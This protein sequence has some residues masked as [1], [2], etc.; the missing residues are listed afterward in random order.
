MWADRWMDGWIGWWMGDWVTEWVNWWVD[1]WMNVWVRWLHRMQWGW[2]HSPD[3]PRMW[4]PEVWGNILL[5]ST[6]LI[7]D[8]YSINDCQVCESMRIN[9]HQPVHRV[10]PNLIP[11]LASVFCVNQIWKH[12]PL[13]FLML[14][15]LEKGDCAWVPVLEF[16][17]WQTSGNQHLLLHPC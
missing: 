12:L 4:I 15:V 1:L 2:E 10:Q 14:L 5:P 16:T 17:T 9:E 11:L 7:R 13:E 8:K 3:F 6:G